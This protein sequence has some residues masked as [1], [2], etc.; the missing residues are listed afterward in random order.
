MRF[1][2]FSASFTFPQNRS[3]SLFSPRYVG[4]H[5]ALEPIQEDQSPPGIFDSLLTAL[6]QSVGHA[7]G[8][9]VRDKTGICSIPLI[10]SHGQKGIFF[11]EKGIPCSPTW[12]VCF[13]YFISTHKYLWIDENLI[14]QCWQL[15]SN[16]KE[17]TALR[18]LLIICNVEN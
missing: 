15:F 5:P 18:G 16:H 12:K 9:S 2:L 6:Q 13:I 1:F 10:P 7:A 11:L 4:E 14:L 17:R 3:I 8:R